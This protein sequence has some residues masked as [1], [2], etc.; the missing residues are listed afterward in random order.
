MGSWL[1]DMEMEIGK[2][3]VF[4]IFL[5]LG[6]RRYG[7]EENGKLNCNGSTFFLILLY[8]ISN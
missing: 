6:F 1:W 8:V 4:F 7:C 2:V 3:D 5:F